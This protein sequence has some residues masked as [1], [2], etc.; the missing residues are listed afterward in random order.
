MS[1][2]E[3]FRYNIKRL[4]SIFQPKSKLTI[5]RSASVNS[6]IYIQN[7]H[8]RQKSF[9]HK[10]DIQ[11]CRYSTLDSSCFRVGLNNS[12]SMATHRKLWE[13]AFICQALDERGMLAMDVKDL[14]SLWTSFQ[15]S[16][17]LTVIHTATD[18]D[19]SD[20]RIKP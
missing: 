1:F 16:L 8:R 7:Y 2:G 10:T 18:L 14:D 5:L 17:L 4:R 20:K 3:R 19:K 9:S 11:L 12:K 13:L 6:V 15:H